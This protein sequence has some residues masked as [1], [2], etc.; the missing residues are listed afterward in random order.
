VTSWSV[1]HS[2]E[3]VHWAVGLALAAGARLRRSLSAAQQLAQRRR[4]SVRRAIKPWSTAHS[5]EP[6]L[7]AV[8]LALA[9]AVGLAVSSVYSGLS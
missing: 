6:V 9:V 2:I 3:A 5:I 8:G 7:W 4:H 1:S